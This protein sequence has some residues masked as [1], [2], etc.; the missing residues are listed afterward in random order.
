MQILLFNK[1]KHQNTLVDMY[2]QMFW[3]S[4]FLKIKD[5]QVY[6]KNVNIFLGWLLP[7]MFYVNL[8]M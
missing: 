3:V 6:I 5:V 8:S 7:D 4:M 2:S 1:I